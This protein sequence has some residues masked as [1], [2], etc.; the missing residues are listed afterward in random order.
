V[1]KVHYIE[2]THVTILKNEK[3]PAAING[4]PPFII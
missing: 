4:E 2:G 3:V 1:V